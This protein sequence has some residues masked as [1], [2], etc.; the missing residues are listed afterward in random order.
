MRTRV[1]YFS[2]DFARI[3]VHTQ[4][5]NDRNDAVPEPL[6]NDT[7]QENHEVT[8]EGGVLTYPDSDVRLEIPPSAVEDDVRARVSMAV[9]ADLDFMHQKLHLSENEFIASPVVELHASGNL[10]F[11]KSVQLTLPHFLPPT[12]SRDKVKVYQGSW[13]DSEGWMIKEL[14]QA[15]KNNLEHE[16][17]NLPQAGIFYV[18]GNREIYV[19]KTHFSIYFI[20][21]DCE[22]EYPPPE[23]FL[24]VY[25]KYEQN[26]NGQRKVNTRLYIWDSRVFITD[27]FKAS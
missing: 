1:T 7:W 23:L 26:E 27:F 21:I 13:S 8:A 22:K 10:Q 14:Q 6:I 5:S 3:S 24:E 25:A 16:S 19:F 2:N 20:C 9:C 11:Q 18:A 15:S 4:T 12:F 17:H